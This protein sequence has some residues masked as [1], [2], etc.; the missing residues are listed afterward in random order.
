MRVAYSIW[1][2]TGFPAK[3]QVAFLRKG[4]PTRRLHY[5]CAIHFDQ[6]LKSYFSKQGQ[7]EEEAF[8]QK[9]LTPFGSCTE[10]SIDG[11]NRNKW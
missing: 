9:S 1:D 2:A 10:W 3:G 5:F 8:L 7:E 4:P 6:A 11:K